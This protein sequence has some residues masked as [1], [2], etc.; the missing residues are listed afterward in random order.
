MK[1]YL[2]Y[3]KNKYSIFRYKSDEN[4]LQNLNIFKNIKY[5]I[6]SND[7]WFCLI[8]RDFR[9]SDNIYFF[10]FLEIYNFDFSKKFLEQIKQE[11]KIENKKT[12]LVWPINISIWNSYRFWNF[13]KNNKI[14]FWEYETDY[15]LNELLL[16]N[17]FSI[18][19]KYLTAERI[20]FNPYKFDKIDNFFLEDLEIINF[21]LDEENLKN[22][23]NLSKKIFLKAPII[24]FIE[25]QKFMNVY[26]ELY[27]N[28]IWEYFLVY[29]WKNIWFL[30][31]FY[32]KDYFVIKTMWILK[33]FRWKWLWNYFLSYIYNIYL[34]KWFKKSYYLYMRENWDALKMQNKNARKY[35]EY[36]TYYINI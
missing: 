23:Y 13:E 36:F 1:K 26:L 25:F 4:I 24:N 32:D 34:K 12:K 29:K 6:I 22:L 10:W 8:F 16:K 30:S 31:S 27:K 2:S 15:R 28:N 21:K 18:Y 7:I 5:K 11:V 9:I 3:I 19:E 17:N 33:E 35:R 14:I 20:W